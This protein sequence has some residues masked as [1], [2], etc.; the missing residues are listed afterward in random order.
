[1]LERLKLHKIKRKTKPIWYLIHLA[2]KRNTHKK[3]L[4]INVRARKDLK[5]EEK[6]DGTGDWLKNDKL[7]KSA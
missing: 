1:M 6:I 5:K 4:T 7:E 3:V 2:Q